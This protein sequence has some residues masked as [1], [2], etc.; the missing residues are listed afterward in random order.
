MLLT[1]RTVDNAS[2]KPVFKGRSDQG[3]GGRSLSAFI[4]LLVFTDSVLPGRLSDLLSFHF[5]L[6]LTRH[7]FTLELL[8]FAAILQ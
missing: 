5:H 3:G 7:P 4:L 8:W 2:L 6:T 1:L